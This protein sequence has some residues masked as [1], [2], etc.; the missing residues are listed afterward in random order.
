MR[1]A[2]PMIHLTQEAARAL[3]RFLSANG[4]EGRPL[5]IDLRSSGCCDAS[6]GLRVDRKGPDDIQKEEEGLEFL[7][8]PEVAELAGRISIDHISEPSRTGF[9]LKSEKPLGEWEGFGT[10]E[11]QIAPDLQKEPAGQT[12][13]A[14]RPI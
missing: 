12:N 2:Q 11:V 13:P 3:G 6:L 5:R 4:L 10:C 14:N 1:K 7:L 9:V 8:R